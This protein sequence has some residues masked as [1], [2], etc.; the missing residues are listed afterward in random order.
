[1]DKVLQ[2]TGNTLHEP[3]TMHA[4]KRVWEAPVIA[5]AHMRDAE[6]GLTGRGQDISVD[7]GNIIYVGIGS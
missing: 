5:V 2:A 3:S 6:L 7:V 1:M 4:P